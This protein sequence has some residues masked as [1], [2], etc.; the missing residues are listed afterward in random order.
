MTAMNGRIELADAPSG[1][2][3]VSLWLPLPPADPVEEAREPEETGPGETR[4]AERA[5]RAENAERADG[6]ATADASRRM[7][8]EARRS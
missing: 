3:K 2:L 1:G 7:T 5:E 8:V 4:E 6:H